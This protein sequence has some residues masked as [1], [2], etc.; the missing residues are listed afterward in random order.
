VR[1]V[2]ETSIGHFHPRTRAASCAAAE[3]L[4]PKM[5]QSTD[6]PGWLQVS[7]H[8]RGGGGGGSDGMQEPE[9]QAKLEGKDVLM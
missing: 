1:N 8:H 3:L 6:F 5:R 2:Y 7:G 9:T 4:D